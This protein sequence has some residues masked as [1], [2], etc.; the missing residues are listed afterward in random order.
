VEKEA[1]FILGLLAIKP[2]HQTRIASTDAITSLVNLLKKYV[3]K[4][5][6]Q[7]L[8]PSAHG[9]CRRASDAITNLAHEN[10]DIKNM[11]RERGGIPPL[12][13]LLEAADIKVGCQQGAAGGAQAGRAVGCHRLPWRPTAPPAPPPFSPAQVQRAS[14]GALRTLAFKNEDNKNQIVEAG[15]LPT[16]I[17]M[18]RSEDTGV[19]YEAVRRPAPPNPRS[20]PDSCRC[21]LGLGRAT[22]D[23]SV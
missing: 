3:D 5:L 7:V 23:L 17:T 16:L 13:A 11:V 21:D 8:L 18:L 20:A 12:V 22:S 1:C 19:H 2:E 9:V 15:A 4:N 6:P 14:A 10:L